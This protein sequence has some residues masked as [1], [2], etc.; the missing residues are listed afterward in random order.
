MYTFSIESML[1][2][3]HLYITNHC[4]LKKL[5]TRKLEESNM[6]GDGQNMSPVMTI[7]VYSIVLYTLILQNNF[8]KDMTYTLNEVTYR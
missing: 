2:K 1:S 7:K 3:R 8:F 6:M 4:P 5:E